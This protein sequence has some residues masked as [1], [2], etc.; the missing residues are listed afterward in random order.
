[1]NTIRGKKK[2]L[3][4]F[5]VAFHIGDGVLLSLILNK[6]SPVFVPVFVRIPRIII[7]G[8]FRRAPRGARTFRVGD[9]AGDSGNLLGLPRSGTASW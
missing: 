2:V 7:R 1:M 5:V 8:S 4:A 9:G 6:A 3:A